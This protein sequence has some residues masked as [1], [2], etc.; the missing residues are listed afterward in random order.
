MLLP[1]SIGLSLVLTAA[2]GGLN[3][4]DVGWDVH[5]R[6]NYQKPPGSNLRILCNFTYPK[7]YRTKDVRVYWKKP[8]RSVCSKDDMDK[9]AF[10]FHTN[11][12]C[13]HD[14]Y[15]GRTR[16]TGDPAR[17][18]C[19]LLIMN[20]TETE[21]KIYLR[22]S[23]MN[24]NFS[25]TDN[26]VSISVLGGAA[27]TSDPEARYPTGL[28]LPTIEPKE[29]QKVK[30]VPVAIVVPVVVVV[31]LVAG[32]LFTVRRKRSMSFTREESGYYANFS[33]A[34]ADATQRTLKD[35]KAEQTLSPP[36]AIDEPVYVN[37]E[38]PQT[39]TL[40]APDQPNHIYGNV[41]YTK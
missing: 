1:W 28:P 32:I 29:D 38:A 15:K 6:H 11:S 33:R 4:S 5:V 25:F 18:D 35:M 20:V 9:E 10:I 7:E 40:Q 2:S 19:T 21:P 37:L 41:D 14:H 3:S 16:L 12:T 27:V 30:L 22:V 34:S 39:E 36:K 23:V 8:G 24:E 17:G 31:L 26:S 13:V